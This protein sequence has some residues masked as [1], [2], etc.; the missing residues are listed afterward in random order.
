MQYFFM[1]KL[2]ADR[3]VALNLFLVALV[4]LLGNF[5]LSYAEAREAT[6]SELST[7]VLSK[8]KLDQA[9]AMY[10]QGDSNTVVAVNALV[11]AATKK[12]PVA[13]YT[14]VN[15]TVLPPSGDK[16]DY[17]SFGPYWWPNEKKPKG[18]WIRKDGV[19]NPITQD[20]GADKVALNSMID[21]VNLLGLA[22]F[23][24]GE[25]KY[26]EKAAELISVWFL[27]AS[28]RMN[29]N[30]NFAQGIP[31]TVDGRGIGI[32]ETRRLYWVLDAVALISEA[33]VMSPSEL[34]QFKVWLADFLNW[35]TDSPLGKDER[36]TKNN[37][38]TF[39]DYQVAAIAL[40]LGEAEIARDAVMRAQARLTSQIE[41][42]GQQPLELERTKP[43]HYSV[44]NAQAY[45][46]LARFAAFLQ[47][48][49]WFAPSK[50]DLRLKK[51]LELLIAIAMKKDTIG[52][53]AEKKI[54]K[55]DL[56]AI[57]PSYAETYNVSLAS[58]AKVIAP[59]SKQ[60]LHCG[61]LLAPDILPTLQ[62]FEKVKYSKCSY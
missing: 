43:F 61:L 58:I 47:E 48:D 54:D 16:H 23:F 53:K 50:E 12:L 9:K 3:R 29:P 18:K 28:T 27:N 32:I 10:Q 51:A 25:K 36:E 4:L 33:G 56:I 5:F 6:S 52:G 40:F 8:V 26:A 42:D 7:V 20:K 21:D 15:K 60:W 59:E 57:M 55:V 44:F 13:P 11:A 14:I 1:P 17:Y 30:L 46:G 38:A 24:T 35:L 37:H 62:S 39:Y 22:Y 41:S 34:S 49:I 31:G 45:T 2:K 19:V